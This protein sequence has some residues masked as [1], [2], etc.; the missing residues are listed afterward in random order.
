MTVGVTLLGSTGSVGTSAL[1]VI[2]RHPDKYR[3]SALS[4]YRNVGRMLDQCRRFHPET[5]VM[6]DRR[7]AGQLREQCEANHLD[8]RV[9]SGEEA[10]PALAREAGNIVI[11]GIVGAVGLMSTIA[12][13]ESGKK[14]LIANKEP[15][16]MLGGFLMDLARENRACLLPLDSE[17]NAIFQCLPQHTLVR[18][19]GI[20]EGLEHQGIKHILLTG[21]GGPFRTLDLDRLDSVTPEQACAHP[22]WR[23]GRKISVDSATMMNKGL[24]LIEACALF[25]VSSDQVEIVIHPQSVIH[26]MV[27]YIDG[28]ILAQLGSPDM[29]VPIASA[30]AW[31]DRIESGAPSLCLKEVAK[32]DFHAPDENRFPALEL[33][34]RAA[35]TGGTLPSIMNAANEV[36]VH[37]FLEGQI[38]FDKIT[39]FVE[40][41][42]D[43]TDNSQDNDLDSVLAADA[44]ARRVC[45]RIMAGQPC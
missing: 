33:A 35:R 8:I 4:G 2:G 34:R 40:M 23:M 26:S 29:R 21:S 6:G 19:H 30:L 43:K 27:E 38:T 32:L 28:S 13:I 45:R 24:E 17:H 16:V 25:G 15:L 10:L 42:M 3:V 41:T 1:D 12:A 18:T 14:V 5:V 20:L 44:A 39:R 7:S 37:A 36:A 9:E 22:N 11:C 31:P